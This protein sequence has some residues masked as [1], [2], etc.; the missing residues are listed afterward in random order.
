MNK[1]NVAFLMSAPYSGA[2]LLS[3]LMN[4]HPEI[5]SDGEIFPY[6]R[7]NDEICSCGERQVSCPHYKYIASGMMNKKNNSYNETFFYYVPRYFNNY[8][9]SRAFEGFWSNEF[10]N[11]LRNFFR[12]ITPSTKRIEKE[13]IELHLGLIAKS[14]EVRGASLYFDGSKSVRRAEFL[15][16]NTKITPKIVHLVRDGRAFCNSFLKNKKLDRSNLL[17]A[18]N[19]WKNHLKKID[20]LRK[21]LPAVEVLVVR[22]DDLCNTPGSQLEKIWKF[23][24]L[25]YSEDFMVFKRS[26]MHIIGNRMRNSY[27]GIV[28]KDESW[29]SQMQGKEIMELNHLLGDE[30]KRFGFKT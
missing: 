13:F 6:V 11:W 7:G 5:S 27:D 24:G 30:L 20:I 16:K 19:A 4:Q 9:L 25:N 2:T 3:I 15:I 22:Y 14:L 29:K 21:R 26:D 12:V 8:Y 18:A 17:V 28:I 10:A 23:L 1:L